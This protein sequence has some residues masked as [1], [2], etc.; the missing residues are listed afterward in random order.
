MHIYV[1]KDVLSLIASDFGLS[2]IY[3][4]GQIKLMDTYQSALSKCIHI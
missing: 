1:T 2:Y 4:I 3:L